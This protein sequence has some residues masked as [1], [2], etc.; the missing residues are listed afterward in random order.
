MSGNNQFKDNNPGGLAVFS[1]G[2][3][4]LNNITS[5]DNG[6][7]VW[8]D[9]THS[10]IFQGVTITGTNLFDNN[11]SAGLFLFTRGPVTANNLTSTDNGYNDTITGY[12][13]DIENWTAA[14]AQ[15]VTLT[16][17]NFIGFNNLT[18]LWLLSNGA[19]SINNLSAD[20][21]G[22]LGALI[23]NCG[24]STL[25]NCTSVGIAAPQN[26]TFTGYVNLDGNSRNGMNVWSYGAI[27]LANVNANNNGQSKVVGGGV[28][29][30]NCDY[31]D[32]VAGH[33]SATLPRAITLTGNNSFDGN[34]TYGLQVNSLGAIT[35]NNVNA[36]NNGNTNGNAGVFLENDFPGAVGGVSV[37]NTAANF[38]NFSNNGG[39]GLKILSRGA[40]T[41]MDRALGTM[42]QMGFT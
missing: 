27:T 5:S 33:C 22:V 11:S 19:V 35:V 26:V 34:F 18:G 9:N 23:V 32:L 30:D 15:P 12:G 40:I 31:G 38:P 41:V 2:F 4:T 36:D 8:V 24:Y 3:I 17:T 6:G 39:N 20:N 21:N 1:N 29:L 42:A 16:G 10:P 25:T 7:G 13:V 28:Y 14:T 37:T